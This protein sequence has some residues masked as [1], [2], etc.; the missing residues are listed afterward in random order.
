M[1]FRRNWF[2]WKRGWGRGMGFGRG[3]G[4]GWFGWGNP[5]AQSGHGMPYG[6]HYMGYGYSYHGYSA[7]GPYGYRPW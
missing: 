5:Y 2:G 7:V 3:R 1:P 4:R 6:Y